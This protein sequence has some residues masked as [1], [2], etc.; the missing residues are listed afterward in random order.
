MMPAKE[1][2]PAAGVAFGSQ[3]FLLNESLDALVELLDFSLEQFR[4]DFV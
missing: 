4:H 2:D 3:L 1:S